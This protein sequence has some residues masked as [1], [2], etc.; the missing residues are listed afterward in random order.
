MATIR[1]RKDKYQALV[2][3][4]SHPTVSKTFTLKSDARTWARETEIQIQKGNFDTAYKPIKETLRGILERYLI[5]VT[6]KKK[7]PEVEAIKIKRLLREPIAARPFSSLKPFHF[8]EFRDERSKKVSGTTT[9]KDLALLSHAIEIATK[10][11]GLPLNANPVRQITK[12]KQNKPRNR[13]L[14]DNEEE[15]LLRFCSQS[16]NH[17][18]LPVV[19][20]AIETA[21]RRGEILGLTWT[22]VEMEKR[23]LHLPITKNG[24]S[25][26]VPLSI[27]AGQ[28]LDGLPRD[29]TGKVFPV[30]TMALRGLWDRACKRANIED[31]NFH[32]LRHEATS[33]FF[34]KGLNV[35][36]VA[37]ITGHK[38]PS[39]LMRYTHLRAEDLA[40]KLG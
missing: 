29:I 11:W 3:L 14:E 24:D 20:M 37:S 22:D 33:R 23:T 19:L 38:D 1:K 26:M 40:V 7:S 34:E 30:T 12:P 32:D 6:P 9:L 10:E 39:M 35:I 36:E 18:L 21:M 25:R 16:Q 15:R 31:L 5:E 27:R 17:W 28:V 13:R 4:S 8:V 2:R